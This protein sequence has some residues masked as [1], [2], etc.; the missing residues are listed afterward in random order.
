MQVSF[1]IPNPL[2]SIFLYSFPLIGGFFGI[3]I[4]FMVESFINAFASSKNNKDANDARYN[5]DNG[6]MQAVEM[7]LDIR[8]SISST[9]RTGFIGFICGMM[10]GTYLSLKFKS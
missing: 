2:S 1:I 4:A 8:D 7:C 10:C 5:G 3:K 6:G 9:L